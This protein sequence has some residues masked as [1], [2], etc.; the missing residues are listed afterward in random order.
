MKR[1]KNNKILTTKF[2][3]TK[4]LINKIPQNPQKNI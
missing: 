4:I 2:S 3:P 1:N